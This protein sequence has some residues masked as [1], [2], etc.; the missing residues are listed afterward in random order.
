MRRSKGEN[1]ESA[2]LFCALG[3]VLKHSSELAVAN[4]VVAEFRD[5]YSACARV[6]ARHPMF[7]TTT[8]NDSVRNASLTTPGS[9]SITGTWHGNHL[10]LI[11]TIRKSYFR[12]NGQDR[13]DTSSKEPSTRVPSNPAVVDALIVA[14]ICC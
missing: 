3:K 5:F 2:M 6:C 13:Q 12:L 8:Y 10:E 11:R 14:R 9:R 1:P 7:P 4:V